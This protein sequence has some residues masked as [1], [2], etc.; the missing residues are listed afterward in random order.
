VVDHIEPLACGGA[1]DPRNMQWQ[2]VAAGKAKDRW[3]RIGCQ[4]RTHAGRG[5]LAKAY[6]SSVNGRVYTGPRGG[7][8]TLTADGH[9]RYLGAGVGGRE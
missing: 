7:K 3:E 4:P 1:D 8:F 6:P 2:S 5:W 9:K